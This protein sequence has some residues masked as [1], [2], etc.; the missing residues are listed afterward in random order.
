[1][2]Q[3]VPFTT[4]TNL[5]QRLSLYQGTSDA[6]G[7]NDYLYQHRLR[8]YNRPPGSDQSFEMSVPLNKSRPPSL[9][10]ERCFCGA[11]QALEL[12]YYCSVKC[13]REDALNALTRGVPY[14]SDRPPTP[15]LPTLPPDFFKPPIVGRG[16]TPSNGS[17]EGLL[18]HI[19]LGPFA[20]PRRRSKPDAIVPRADGSKS[21][22]SHA[23]CSSTT[24]PST[25]LDKPQW[26]SHYRLL[27]EK[28]S[29]YSIPDAIE[30]AFQVASASDATNNSIGSS[31]TSSSSK[32]KLTQK[33]VNDVLRGSFGQPAPTSV[34]F[35]PLQLQNLRQPMS[36]QSTVSSTRVYSTLQQASRGSSTSSALYPI[37]PPGIDL[38]TQT[39]AS[40]HRA[41]GSAFGRSEPSLLAAVRSSTIEFD[42]TAPLECP[43]PLPN[44]P[45]EGGAV[46]LL[47]PLRRIGSQCSLS[48]QNLRQRLPL[49]TDVGVRPSAPTQ[50]STRLGVV[51]RQTILFNKR[52]LP[53]GGGPT[54]LSTDPKPSHS[55]TGG[56]PFFLQHR[57]R[58]TETSKLPP[59]PAIEVEDAPA[60][61]ANL[62][63]SLNSSRHCTMAPG[64][65][66]APPSNTLSPRVPAV[67][68]TPRLDLCPSLL[69]ERHQTTVTIIHDYGRE[70][71][72]VSSPSTSE[73]PV[74]PED[75]AFTLGDSRLHPSAP[76]ECC[77]S[78]RRMEKSDAAMF[79]LHRRFEGGMVL[80]DELT[81]IGGKAFALALQHE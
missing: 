1:M 34:D 81:P 56:V 22:P 68:I 62:E 32:G 18:C 72:E 47:L 80:D 42:N 39:L 40:R 45:L 48:S 69:L 16:L 51:V 20:P 55:R 65:S 79:N 77:R 35:D 46:R 60:S 41:L 71:D 78:E 9:P 54:K 61:D 44:H 57:S 11:P 74:T 4:P 70:T 26:K 53:I 15:P 27:R 21:K 76:M 13:A 52:R 7:R 25:G 49:K 59:S 19:D 66:K 73:S 43:P 30:T 12:E 31:S 28:E 29:L 37:L 2:Q 75:S 50:P 24:A 14:A 64:S 17:D 5:S 58:E 38:T 63:R 67:S 6:T 8:T 23:S 10:R 36:S 3:L 33:M